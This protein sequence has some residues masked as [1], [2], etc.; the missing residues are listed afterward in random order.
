MLLLQV[1]PP[2]LCHDIPTISLLVTLDFDTISP[3]LAYTSS[4]HH[5]RW[6]LLPCDERINLPMISLSSS[7]GRT[8]ETTPLRQTLHALTHFVHQH[9]YSKQ[10][11][12]CDLKCMF[13][14]TY[15]SMFT[16]HLRPTVTC[17]SGKPIIIGFEDH[18]LPK[19]WR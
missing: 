16:Q 10:H 12:S 13:F 8:P 9:A 4:P 19:L 11:T 14:N 17:D 2:C 1:C 7:S 18:Y 5:R 3:T 6:T 15:T